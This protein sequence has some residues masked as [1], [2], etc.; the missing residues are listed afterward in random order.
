MLWFQKYAIV[1]KKYSRNYSYCF[2]CK[3]KVT[4]YQS[5]LSIKQKK[6]KQD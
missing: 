3:T 6:I 5:L 2:Y 1:P 4:W